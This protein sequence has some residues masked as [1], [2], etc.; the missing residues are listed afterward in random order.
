MYNDV[1]KLKAIVNKLFPDDNFISFKN[2]SHFTKEQMTTEMT[3]IIR[4]CTTVTEHGSYNITN[5]Q[6]AFFQPIVITNDCRDEIIRNLE[7]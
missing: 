7:R 3:E 2:A 5:D 6:E 1:E 4:I